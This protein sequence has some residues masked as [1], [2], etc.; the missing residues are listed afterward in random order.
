MHAGVNLSVFSEIYESEMRGAQVDGSLNP[1]HW[2]WSCIWQ[3]N[4]LLLCYL[5]DNYIRRM[6]CQILQAKKCSHK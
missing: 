4:L 6:S 2:F 5:S 3:S 1:P